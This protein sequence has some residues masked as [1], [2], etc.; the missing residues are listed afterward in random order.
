V[1]QCRALLELDPKYDRALDLMTTSYLQLG[2]YDEAVDVLNRWRRAEG[3]WTWASRATAYSRLGHVE[4]ARREL[5]KIEQLPVSRPDRTPTLLT[6]YSGTGQNE[7]LLDLL[8]KAYSEHSNAV[9]RIKVDPMYDPIRNDPRFKDLL[10]RIG[11]E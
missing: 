4:E 3:S 7:R 8:E 11:L 9:V 10:R 5:V 6:A 1:K 2:R